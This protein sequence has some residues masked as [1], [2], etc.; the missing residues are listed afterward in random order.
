VTHLSANGQAVRY[1]SLIDGGHDEGRALT[2]DS[3]G[4][5]YLTGMTDSQN[6]PMIR[7][8]Q[9]N[10]SGQSG[11]LIHVSVTAWHSNEYYSDPKTP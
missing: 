8:R 9:R 3:G 7:S 4:Y 10:I 5:I 1:S 11:F 6:Y 2:I